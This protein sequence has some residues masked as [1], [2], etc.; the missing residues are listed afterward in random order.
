MLVF[1]CILIFTT[2]C[3]S[4]PV[5]ESGGVVSSRNIDNENLIG[6]KGYSY[7]V[8]GGISANALNSWIK[9]S[10]LSWSCT[11]ASYVPSKIYI[12]FD[13]YRTLYVYENF[14][15]FSDKNGS[16]VAKCSELSIHSLINKF[17]KVTGK[18]VPK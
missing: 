16:K 7:V 1:L 12:S 17:E 14:V 13:E 11:M 15:I 5:F 6:D 8:I 3:S 2:S 4:R 10:D 18:F 9:E